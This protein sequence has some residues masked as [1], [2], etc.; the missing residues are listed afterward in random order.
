MKRW[1]VVRFPTEEEAEGY[2]NGL[3]IEPDQIK[4]I[5]A[6]PPTGKNAGGVLLVCWLSAHQQRVEQ[7]QQQPR[8]HE[9]Q[10]PPVE[11]ADADEARSPRAVRRR[12]APE[13]DE[14]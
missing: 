12:A 13:A 8:T 5:F 14:S 2:L 4:G 3:S 1:R 6:N 10:A 11:P 7:L 9:D